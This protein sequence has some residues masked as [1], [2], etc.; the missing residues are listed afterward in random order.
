VKINALLKSAEA[1]EVNA[2]RGH[3]S[4]PGGADGPSPDLHSFRTFLYTV[5]RKRKDTVSPLP[6]PFCVGGSPPLAPFLQFSD[7]PPLPPPPKFPPPQGGGRPPG[8]FI[9]GK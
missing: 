8:L 1:G 2:L 9:N 4:N 6:P 3:L 5:S 7:A